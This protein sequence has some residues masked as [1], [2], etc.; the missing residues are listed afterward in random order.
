MPPVPPL[1]PRVQLVN[2]PRTQTSTRVL[3]APL[4]H[5][6]ATVLQEPHLHAFYAPLGA[7]P[8]LLWARLPVF[9]VP[10][11]LTLTA[12]PLFAPPVQLVSIHPRQDSLLAILVCLVL[13]P[14]QVRRCVSRVSVIQ[15]LQVLHSTVVLFRNSISKLLT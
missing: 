9:D 13:F 7:M 4:E 3:R 8:T 10:V 15:Y 2:S 12:V 14:E 1:A 5:T 6:T 11:V